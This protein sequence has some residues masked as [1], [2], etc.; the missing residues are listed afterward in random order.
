MNLECLELC[1][2][3]KDD[4]LLGMPNDLG[5][6]INRHIQIYTWKP[7]PRYASDFETIWEAALTDPSLFSEGLSRLQRMVPEPAIIAL[8]STGPVML[9]T[10]STGARRF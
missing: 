6:I 4:L 10:T 1:V 2:D 9:G 3:T 5:Q 7:E 8:L